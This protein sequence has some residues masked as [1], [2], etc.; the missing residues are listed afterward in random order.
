MLGIFT[1]VASRQTLDL[2]VSA[3]QKVGCCLPVPGRGFR[4]LATSCWL[5]VVKSLPSLPKFMELDLKLTLEYRPFGT[6]FAFGEVRLGSLLQNRPDLLSCSSLAL[7]L[8][9]DFVT[10]FRPR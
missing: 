10:A 9:Q 5:Y 1:L 6:R 3:L 4:V 7:K 2:N 8:T